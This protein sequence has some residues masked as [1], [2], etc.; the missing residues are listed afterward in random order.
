MLY[1]HHTS[2]LPDS[3]AILGRR[4]LGT[5]ARNSPWIHTDNQHCEWAGGVGQPGDL[6]ENLLS[7]FDIPLGAYGPHGDTSASPYATATLA[8]QKQRYM[9]E[10]QQQ[11]QHSS[12][13]C[14]QHP[15]LYKDVLDDMNKKVVGHYDNTA[16][17]TPTTPTAVSPPGRISPTGDGQCAQPAVIPADARSISQQQQQQQQKPPTFLPTLNWADILPPPPRHPRRRRCRPTRMTT[18][19]MITQ[20][21]VIAAEDGQCEKCD[22]ESE[23]EDP[24]KQQVPV[25]SNGEKPQP[26]PRNP[27]M[28]QRA[29]QERASLERNRDR[30]PRSFAVAAATQPQLPRT[31]SFESCATEDLQTVNRALFHRH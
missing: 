6:K 1:L 11:Q 3:S 18:A 10:H 8:M 16:C 19:R 28:V 9:Q 12:R 20:P 13:S 24:K 7:S 30:V 23:E 29:V 25:R 2:L 5:Y 31:R 15:P 21:C 27:G 14:Q 26:P 4:P 17:Q 22:S